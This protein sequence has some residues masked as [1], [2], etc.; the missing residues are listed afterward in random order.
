MLPPVFDQKEGCKVRVRSVKKTSQQ[1]TQWLICYYQAAQ[2]RA[3][4]GNDRDRDL[5]AK[6]VQK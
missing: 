4:S 5:H 6:A 3:S 1:Q 2:K